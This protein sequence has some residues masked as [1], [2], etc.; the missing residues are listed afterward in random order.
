MAHW[1]RW[2]AGP[3]CARLAVALDAG[4]K[5]LCIGCVGTVIMLIGVGCGGRSGGS[6]GD[7]TPDDLI[8]TRSYVWSVPVQ[9]AQPAWHP[10]RLQLVTRG[11][12][13]IQLFEEGDPNPIR[14]RVGTQNELFD[15]VWADAD[16]V[17][18]GPRTTIE[19]GEDGRLVI[20][21]A[22]VWQVRVRMDGIEDPERISDVGY[23]P[24]VWGDDIL[25]A[26]EDQLL[27]ADGDTPELYDNGFEAMPDP[28][29]ERLAFHTRPLRSVDWWTGIQGP[30]ELVIRWGDEVVDVIPGGIEAAWCPWG[31]IVVTVSDSVPTGDE[32]TQL[33]Y[34][35]EPGAEPVVLGSDLREPAPHPTQP[36]IA[37]VFGDDEIVFLGI[38]R[39]RMRRTEWRGRRPQW[40]PRGLRLLTEQPDAATGRVRLRIHVFTMRDTAR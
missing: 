5:R 3:A 35:A 12:S 4:M 19:R 40:H 39:S 31:G 34:I 6:S 21:S 24:R 16:H 7:I 32:Q 18:F 8:L 13:A 17:V 33:V 11:A 1:W 25:V 28:A 30:G 22:G 36:V 26:Q 15:P 14:M 27:I 37:A 10:E 9:P 23:R 38:D 20:P 29:G 2:S